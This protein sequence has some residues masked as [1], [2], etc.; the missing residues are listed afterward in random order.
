MDAWVLPLL[1]RLRSAACC[2]KPATASTIEACSAILK[3]VAL[4]CS[5]LP[6]CWPPSCQ[7]YT[8][9]LPSWLAT[10]S[11]PPRLLAVAAMQLKGEEDTIELWKRRLLSPKSQ[12]ANVRSCG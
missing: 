12:T 4:P 6:P 7:E 11:V 2:L 10:A 9:T 5:L 1:A 3:D 8:R